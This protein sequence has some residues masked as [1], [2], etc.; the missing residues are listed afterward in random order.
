VENIFLKYLL[1]MAGRNEQP[2]EEPRREPHEERQGG[3]GGGGRNQEDLIF[4]NRRRVR[5]SPL[6]IRGEKHDLPVLPKGT[7]KEFSRDGTIDAKRH[8]NLFLDVCDFHRVEYDDV[9]VRLFLQTL[10][11]RAYE[12]YM[13]L[14][15]R[16]I[17][18]FNDLEAMFLTMFA[19]PVAYHT[20]LTNFTQIGL[21]K[22]ER[23]RYFNLRFN[24]TL[25][26][27]PEDKIPNDPVIL[28]CY[29][30]VMPP[31]VK[32]AIRT[33]QMDTLEEAMIKA[34][35]M[36]E[37]MIEM[38]VDPDIIL[39]KVQRQLGGLNID[40]QGASS[41]RKNE[42]KKSRPIQNQT[43]GGGFFKGTIPD[44]KVDPVA[45][46]ETKQRIEIAQMNRTIRKMKNEITRLRR[47]DNYVANLRMSVQEKRRNP[48]QENRVRF[49]NTD[50]PQRQRVPRK[51]IPNA[52][53]LDDVYDE[54]MV[55][56]GNDYLPDESSETVQM[57]GCETSM[58]IFEEGDND[59][60]S[61]ENV[62][63]T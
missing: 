11:G 13:T 9:M 54:K 37:I 30:N 26:K 56:Q 14:P 62:S 1:D 47:G 33:S 55:E 15:T 32:Y 41:S 57:D 29:K 4:G 46:Q 10:S 17:G 52:V 42:E 49:E 5:D 44:V 36:E 16:S 43:I 34:T 59:P 28:G 7:L 31:N 53:V 48:P 45:A 58:Y 24:K 40:D 18:S 60:D 12:W 19:P 50:N 35:E 25:S 22:N 23:I 27:I 51:P 2:R 63:Q 3:G 20:L 8:L 21:R 6:N 61:Q 38:G 39:G